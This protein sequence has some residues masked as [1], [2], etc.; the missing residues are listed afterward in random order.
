MAVRSKQMSEMAAIEGGDV[1]LGIYIDGG[2]VLIS[3]PTEAALEYVEQLRRSGAGIS[4]AM[5]AGRRAADVA[6]LLS[7]AAS[8][9]TSSGGGVFL[10]VA[11]ESLP[12]LMHNGLIP[13]KDGVHTVLGM[14][15]NGGQFGHH[16]RFVGNPVSNPARMLSLQTMAVT[17]ALR[18][19]IAETADAIERVEGKVDA[20]LDLAYAQ[21]VGNV[22]GLHETLTHHSGLLEETGV[23]TTSDWNSVANTEA[24]LSIAINRLRTHVSRAF[25]EV[26][27]AESL[28][29]RTDAVKALDSTHRIDEILSLLV[30][31]ED[32]MFKFQQLRVAHVQRTEPDYLESTVASARRRLEENARL[33]EELYDSALAT[34]NVASVIR[35]LEIHRKLTAS[36]LSKSSMRMRGASGCLLRGTST[37]GCPMARD[38]EADDVGCRWRGGSADP[39]CR[40][41]GQASRVQDRRCRIRPR[42]SLGQERA[43]RC[44]TSI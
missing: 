20:L 6:A 19:A 7:T 11:D 29:S 3:G 23:V 2:E 36:K 37:A 38:R 9:A 4:S 22:L 17:L 32:A 39:G 18:A 30:V 14:T 1:E 40:K 41:W 24:Q 27:D 42:R 33:D 16:L 35:P 8:A 43:G 12:H 31:V 26:A 15:R 28:G 13:T 25:N 44:S 10:R 34:L 5:L 21:Q